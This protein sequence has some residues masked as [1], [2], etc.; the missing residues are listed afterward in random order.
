VY[1]ATAAVGGRGSV[2]GLATDVENTAERDFRRAGEMIDLRSDV[3]TLPTAEM[4]EAMQEAELGD[5]KVDED[6]TVL[7]LEG[8]GYRRRPRRDS[9]SQQSESAS[10]VASIA[11]QIRRKV[12]RIRPPVKA[13]GGKFYLAREI[14]PILLSAPGKPKEYLEPCAFVPEDAQS[15]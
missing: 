2:F 14:V 7:H 12:K 6:P 15:W 3:K 8:A 5:S 9:P 4:L 13:H 10:S 1:F 11:S